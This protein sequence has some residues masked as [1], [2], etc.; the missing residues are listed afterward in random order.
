MPQFSSVF[1][2]DFASKHLLRKGNYCYVTQNVTVHHPKLKW[3]WKAHPGLKKRKTQTQ[4]QL[5]KILVLRNAFITPHPSVLLRR[6]KVLQN[7]S[8]PQI[9][10]LDEKRTGTCHIPWADPK[11]SHFRRQFW[12]LAFTKH[13]KLL[14]QVLFECPGYYVR[15]ALL[16]S[17]KKSLP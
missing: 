5:L 16:K 1:H 14:I 13:A 4:K 8:L 7:R 10:K 12:Y 2:E 17:Y 11:F 15:Q 9:L 3:C 6:M